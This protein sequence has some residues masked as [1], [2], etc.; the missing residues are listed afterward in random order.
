MEASDG[1]VAQSNTGVIS[2]RMG[3]GNDA[4][5]FFQSGEEANGYD[6]GSNPWQMKERRVQKTFYKISGDGR[7]SHPNN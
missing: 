4:K 7:P 3:S 5:G 6:K 1:K 2:Q